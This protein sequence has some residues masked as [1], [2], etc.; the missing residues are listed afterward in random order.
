MTGSVEGGCEVQGDA[1]RYRL[2]GSAGYPNARALLDAG[3]RAFAS[4]ADV[5]VDL[6]GLTALDSAGLAV[7]VTWLAEARAAG[8]VL[9][10]VGLPE[11]LVPAA[12]VAGVERLVGGTTGA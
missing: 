5:E 12:R 11:A 7:L 4:A 10:Y 3:R 1:G 8:R 2:A 6:A 9:R